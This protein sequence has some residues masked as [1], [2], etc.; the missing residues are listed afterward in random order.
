LQKGLRHERAFTLVELLVVI[1]IIGMLIAL[2]LP[3]VQ[4]AREAARRMQCSNNLKQLGLALHNFHDTNDEMTS[5]VWIV[6][7]IGMPSGVVSSDVDHPGNTSASRFRGSGHVALLPFVEQSA[8]YS[9]ASVTTVNPD[10]N[11]PG[12]ASPWAVQPNHLL[13][14]SDAG[15][16]GKV[17]AEAGRNNY[18]FSLGD[19]AEAH[20]MDQ[21][22]RNDLIQIPPRN[23]ERVNH[24]GPFTLHPHFTRSFGA[25][26]DGLSNTIGLSESIVGVTGDRRR[27]NT[28]QWHGVSPVIQNGTP[29][30]NFNGLWDAN[31]GGWFRDDIPSAGIANAGNAAGQITPCIGARWASAL[32]PFTSFTPILSPNSASGR[33]GNMDSR[34]VISA[35]SHHTG[36]VNVVF[37]DGHVRFVSETINDGGRGASYL[38]NGLGGGTARSPFGVWGAMGSI[39]GGESVS[40]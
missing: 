31:I 18:F 3:A 9:A 30:G 5:G 39:N 15:R 33:S 29:S 35:S 4:A 20:L 37:L 23:L 6:P 10:Q 40:L 34:H 12:A 17:P 28:G 26:A 38:R 36:G 22:A 1:A 11:S 14:P 24:R 21:E 7:A 13:C 25:I 2:L 32:V 19:R 16:G 8:L 27:V